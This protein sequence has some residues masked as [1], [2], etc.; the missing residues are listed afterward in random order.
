MTDTSNAAGG[1]AAANGA[2]SQQPALGGA[3]AP[4]SGT[5]WIATLPSELKSVVET[6][7]WKTPADAIS[8]YVNVEGLIGK[9]RLA[10]P[11][12]DKTGAVDWSGWTGWNDLGRPGKPEDYAFKD[13]DGVTADPAMDKWFRGVAHKHGLNGWQAQ[14]FRTAWNTLMTGM[15]RETHEKAVAAAA[16]AE[17]TLKQEFGEKYPGT[18]DLINRLAAQFGGKDLVAEFEK[19]GLGRSAPMFRFLAKLAA[20]FAEDGTETGSRHFGGRMTK[21]E[22]QAALDAMMGDAQQMA[23]LTTADHP[24]HAVLT[25]RRQRFLDL[26]HGTESVR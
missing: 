4:A 7:A 20:P 5:D 23:A 1:A 12:K 24:E 15:Q 26:I 16:Q 3:A 6:K 9:Q 17:A 18:L 22:A 11:D 8:S 13:A 10:L 2:Q 19:T 21:G 14:E 25:E